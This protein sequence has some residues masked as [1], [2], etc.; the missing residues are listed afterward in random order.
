MYR[1]QRQSIFSGS[2][3]TLYL[4]GI[5]VAVFILE[6]VAYEFLVRNFALI[7]V[8]VTKRFY[9]W[10]FLTHMFL[11]GGLWH[12]FFNM[13]ALFIF[14]LPL[15]RHWG[16]NKYLKYYIVAGLG[17]GLLHYLI[18][19]MSPIPSLGASGAVYGLLL[20]FGLTFPNR[21]LYINFL[22]PIKA[23]YAVLIF[24]GIELF[25]GITGAQSGIAH[26]A[27]LGG[28][29][30]GLLY[31]KGGDWIGKVKGKGRQSEIFR[32]YDE[33]QKDSKKQRF[34]ELMDKIA[35]KGYDS[36]TER[37]KAELDKLSAD[38][39]SDD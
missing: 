14:G 27:H 7:P 6:L 11:H 25:L 38:I 28:L 31:L 8:L 24:G 22:I 2:N 3:I 39:Y 1:R 23:K 4:I 17:G 16:S 33:K 37:E 32:Q 34:D 13:F 21:V 10:Q 36:L 12:L 9:L 30:T 15:E 18:D 35:A 26:F 19:P 29:L 20:A 5:N